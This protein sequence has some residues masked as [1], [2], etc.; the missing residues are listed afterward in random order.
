MSNSY[1][2]WFEVKK[3]SREPDIYSIKEPGHVE[4]VISYLIVGSE[5]SVLLDSGLGIGN[6]ES[7]VK[8]LTSLPVQV[9]NT[10][11][12]WDH[13]GGNQHFSNVAIHKKEVANLEKGID[14]DFLMVQM[15]DEYLL[16]SLP[17]SFK[18]EK[19]SI[20]PCH[21]TRLLKD[22]EF[23]D[24]GNYQLE[25][26][27]MPGHSP[28]SVCLWNEPC[29]HLF[30]GDVIYQGP[31]FAHLPG[32]NLHDYQASIRKLANFQD[33]I[34]LL[35]PAHND[36]PLERPFLKEVIEGFKQLKT[37]TGDYIQGEGWISYSFKRFKIIVPR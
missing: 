12:H 19:Y 14:Q 15:R 22:G 17:A 32:S 25:V 11:S 28:G 13:I 37:S 30:T 29:G 18:L 8:Q 31:L 34:K 3:H 26:L 35:F 9:V 21:P 23:L 27:H 1:Q 7:V 10:H 20:P 6:I 36:T 4:E 5:S 2:K 33:R 24:L 16:W